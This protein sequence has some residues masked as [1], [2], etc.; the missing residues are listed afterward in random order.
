MAIDELSD[1]G[2]LQILC[3]LQ[4]LESVSDSLG[5][6]ITDDWRNL[7]KLLNAESDELPKIAADLPRVMA[8]Q[9]LR[10]RKA[11]N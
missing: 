6:D 8:D 11:L 7:L 4:Y 2:R 10:M 5:V 9:V 3:D 1:W